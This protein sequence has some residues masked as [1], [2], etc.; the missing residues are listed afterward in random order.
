M[1]ARELIAELEQQDMELP[2]FIGDLH[3]GPLDVY[4]VETEQ[5]DIGKWENGEFLGYEK[6]AAIV[7]W[8]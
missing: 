7:L 4:S 6:I 5:I 1:T 8:R 2:V 3:L